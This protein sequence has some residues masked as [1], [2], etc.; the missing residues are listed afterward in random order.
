[1]GGTRNAFKRTSAARQS[2]FVS[3]STSTTSAA[4]LVIP[5]ADTQTSPI[6]SRRP[7]RT[8][9]PSV[10]DGRSSPLRH[11]LWP[12]SPRGARKTLPSPDKTCDPQTYEEASTRSDAAQQNWMPLAGAGSRPSSKWRSTR[13]HVRR[14]TSSSIGSDPNQM[15]A[16]DVSNTSNAPLAHSH[17]SC[18][19]RTP[20]SP[21]P[22]RSS[23]ATQPT[24]D[25]S[26]FMPST[27][28]SDI[29]AERAIT[30]WLTTLEPMVGTSYRVCHA[31]RG[32]H[33]YGSSRPRPCRP[34]QHCGQ[35]VV[36]AG[37]RC[38]GLRDTCRS[39]NRSHIPVLREMGMP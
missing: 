15:F 31:H 14:I 17:T 23:V 27:A 19:T 16:L 5:V 36:V 18:W 21:P 28:S 1:M 20:T 4:A 33:L 32:H 24:P 37:H 6:A 38:M 35:V 13:S 22:S 2:H 9:R 12:D 10:R 29:F 34:F 11:F 26:M 7:K 39:F 25:S 3:L 8:V 30:S